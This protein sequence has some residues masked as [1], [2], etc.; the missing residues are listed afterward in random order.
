MSLL[1]FCLAQAVTQPEV[2]DQKVVEMVQ[3]M[4]GI[5]TVSH[6]PTADHD[7]SKAGS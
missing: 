4:Q 6:L 7:A 5:G 1:L 3:R 2:G